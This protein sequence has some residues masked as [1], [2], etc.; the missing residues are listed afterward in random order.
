[1]TSFAISTTAHSTRPQHA[2]RA[3]S[4]EGPSRPAIITGRVLSGVGVAFLT[5]D[6]AVKLLM[7]PPALEGTT[8][9]GYPVSVIFGLGLLQAFLLIAYLVPRSAVVGAIL[10]TGYLGGA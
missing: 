10:W 7:L 4:G 1:M 2:Q 8:D 3:V 6:A 9:L 5:F